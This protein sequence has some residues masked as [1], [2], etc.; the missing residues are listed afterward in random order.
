MTVGGR[1]SLSQE[2]VWPPSFGFGAVLLPTAQQWSA[3]AFASC[4]IP[5]ARRF[6]MPN[7][8]LLVISSS[9]LKTVSSSLDAKEHSLLLMSSCMLKLHACQAFGVCAIE[10][11]HRVS[12]HFRHFYFFR[13]CRSVCKLVLIIQAF[14]TVSCSLQFKL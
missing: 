5:V 11:P 9:F 2:V 8:M 6:Q 3:C 13:K 1:L 10:R 12:P 4:L 7:G 14:F